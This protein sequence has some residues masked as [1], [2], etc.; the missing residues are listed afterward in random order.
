MLSFACLFS[1]MVICRSGNGSVIVHPRTRSDIVIA[2]TIMYTHVRTHACTHARTHTQTHTHTHTHAR[3]RTHTHT[4]TRT[5]AHSRTHT[6]ARMHAHARTHAH[7]HAH[8]R[9]HTHARTHAHAH[10][11]TNKQKADRPPSLK[12]KK[13]KMTCCIH[14]VTENPRKQKLWS[15]P[16]RKPNTVDGPLKPQVSSRSEHSFACFNCCQEFNTTPQ[17][18]PPPV[19]S[20][21]DAEMKVLLLQKT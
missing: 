11:R 18:P 17:P 5:H 9:T 16:S 12:K 6:H 21:S 15:D 1:M 2:K 4:Y 14:A 10:T 3:A 8:A 20:T 13:K 19:Y 7:T